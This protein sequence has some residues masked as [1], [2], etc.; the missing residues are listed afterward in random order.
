[1]NESNQSIPQM[2]YANEPPPTPLRTSDAPQ[3]TTAQTLTGIFFEPSRTFDALRERPRFLIAAIIIIALTMIFTVAFLQR[4]GFEQ[5]MR[6]A[7]ET[8]QPDM[9]PAQRERVIAMQTGTVGKTLAYG[10]PLIIFSLLIAVGAGL[11]MLGTMAMAGSISY[12]Q[13]LSVWVYSF[14]PPAVLSFIGNM[15]VLLLKQKDDIDPMKDQRGLVHANLGAFVDATAHPVLATA[16]SGIDLFAFLGL[17][18]AALGLR[19]VGKLSAGAAWSVVIALYLLGIVMRV[20]LATAFG[21][22]S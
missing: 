10:S 7:I 12:K 4:V 13:A 22:P 8:S 18:L 20:A 11:Y 15:A 3:M 17:F 21:R 5:M 14:L 6:Q 19:R 16:L 2:S 1:M 9:D